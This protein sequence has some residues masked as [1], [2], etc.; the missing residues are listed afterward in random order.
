MNYICPFCHS[1]NEISFGVIS[2]GRVRC[3]NC[4]TIFPKV[5]TPMPQPMTDFNIKRIDILEEQVASLQGKIK[6]W[7]CKQPG[8]P[9]VDWSL[10]SRWHKWAAMDADG[11]WHSYLHKPECTRICFDNDESEYQYIPSEYAPQFSGDWTESL[12]ER[13]E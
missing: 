13:P 6:Q 11:A 8:K 5:E 10:Y 1:D 3:V 4:K 12:C 7:E 9:V 2:S